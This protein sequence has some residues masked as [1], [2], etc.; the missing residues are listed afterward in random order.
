MDDTPPIGN[1]SSRFGNPAF[2]TFYDNAA[3]LIVSQLNGGL[4]R[5]F[6]DAVPE[7]ARY[8]QESFG[9]RKRIDYGT[10]HETNFVAFLF[11]L[12]SLNVISDND[13]E[14]VLVV[15]PRYIHVMRKL[16][17]RCVGTCAMVFDFFA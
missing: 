15:F 3:E 14:L 2:R 12:D 13:T 9:D 11:C 17:N 16:Q 5:S 8:L 1:A 7:V 4:L 6:G 10:G